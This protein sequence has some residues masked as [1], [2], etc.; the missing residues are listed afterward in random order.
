MKNAWI[1]FEIN[2]VNGVHCNAWQKKYDKRTDE[3]RDTD[4]GKN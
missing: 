3:Q 2:S 1:I 4:I